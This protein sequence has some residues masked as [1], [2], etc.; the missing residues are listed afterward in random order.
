[1]T[2]PRDK[3]AHF[4]HCDFQVHSPRDLRWSGAD[5]VTDDERA[6]YAKELIQACRAKGL[7][8]IAIT[9]H[10]DFAFFPY[11][12]AAA[13]DERNWL[14]DP[15]PPGEQIIVFPG[16]ELTL[17]APNCQAILILDSDFPWTCPVSVDG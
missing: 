13:R 7:D 14:D 11:V 1:M 5:A 16:L 6:Q 10:H 12:T 15:L 8:A 17:T 3:G 2:D 4:F 9:D